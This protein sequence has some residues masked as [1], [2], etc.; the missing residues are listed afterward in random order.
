MQAGSRLK[1]RKMLSNL[2]TV[3]WFPLTLAICE[4]INLSLW[5]LLQV[6][7]FQSFSLVGIRTSYDLTERCG[8]TSILMCLSVIFSITWW[9]P[10]L[11]CL[12]NMTAI[13]VEDKKRNQKNSRLAWVL[14]KYRKW[15]VLGIWKVPVHLLFVEYVV[16]VWSFLIHTL[17][18]VERTTHSLFTVTVAVQ[19]K[20]I[21]L[22]GPSGISRLN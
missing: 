2:L 19:Y 4:G 11:N 9:E 6:K 18:T 13:H 10:P 1:H 17:Y 8:L 15:R 21:V 22:I 5:P 20:L 7:L 16:I 14:G 12:Q 3:G